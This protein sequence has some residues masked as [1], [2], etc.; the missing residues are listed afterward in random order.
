MQNRLMFTGTNSNVGKTT[1]VIGL[2][3]AFKNRG[4]KVQGFKAGPDYIDPAFHTF[5]TGVK[6]RN[7]DTWMLSV[8]AIQE[9]LARHASCA[10]LSI[11]EGVMGMFDGYG[12]QNIKGSSAHLA[13]VTK[14]PVILII[15][16]S[17][18]ALS[19]AAEVLG[20]KSFDTEVDL[21]GVIVNKVSGEHHYQLIKEAI[22]LHVGI[23]CVGYLKK[24]NDISLKSR[25][26]GL[27]PSVEVEALDEKI[28]LAA[29]M[30]EETVDLERILEISSTVIEYPVKTLPK[31][32]TCRLGVAYDSAFNFYYEDNIDLLESLGCEIIR[33]SPINDVLPEVDGLYFG[34]GFPEVF[35][36]KLEENQLIRKQ[37]KEASENAM[38]I[39][40]ECGGFM[41][42][43]ES[44][45]DFKGH[46]F[47]MCGIY[48]ARSKMT[49]KLQRFGYVEGHFTDHTILGACQTPFK[50]HE[51][52][53]SI[54]L[55][56]DCYKTYALNKK[57]KTWTC[58]S[59][60]QKTLAGYP[61]IHFY[62]NKDIAKTFVKSCEEYRRKNV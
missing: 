25:H 27:I 35:A 31:N 62:T 19:A 3:R 23:P 11:M 51:F 4:L 42:L 32:K 18:V 17:G 7:L 37:I 12:V 36:Q 45:E 22:E 41:Y 58:G 33:F 5:A 56:E 50:G 40:A 59:V 61:H 52:H 15:D 8:E 38:P 10:D 16:G 2:M 29:R 21:K 48:P 43:T 47:D 53:R 60:S 24:N 46:T 13:K 44:I 57:G 14:T 28:D 6:S 39:F 1:V 49:D 9:L 54:V 30:L 55:D 20:Y 26:L 34:G